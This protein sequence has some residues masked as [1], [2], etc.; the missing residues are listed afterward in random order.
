MRDRAAG[1]T[2]YVVVP[3]YV[4][5]ISLL[6]L[7]VLNAGFEGCYALLKVLRAG[8]ACLRRHENFIF[9]HTVRT[10]HREGTFTTARH[11]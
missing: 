8:L 3:T 9:C 4:F 11:A 5:E 6:L 1:G 2:I 7:E 10:C